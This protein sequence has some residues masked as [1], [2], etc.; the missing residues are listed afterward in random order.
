MLSAGRET[1][2][3]SLFQK[4]LALSPEYPSAL[5]FLARVSEKHKRSEDAI[6]YLKRAVA[7]SG[8][9]PKYIHALGM[10]YAESGRSEEARRLLDELRGQA[11]QHYVDPDYLTSLAAKIAE[12]SRP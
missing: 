11:K 10:V 12:P 8:R 6:G 7:S 3:A 9:T 4:A 2:A 1:D 5:Y